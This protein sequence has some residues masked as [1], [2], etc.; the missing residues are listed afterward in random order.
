MAC[1]FFV[2]CLKYS[3]KVDFPQ[4]AFPVMK[5]LD[6]VF[7]ISSKSFLNSSVNINEEG[8]SVPSSNSIFLD[9]I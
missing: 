1:C 4:P 6:L 8:N 7:S 5:R 9:I 2:F 3:S